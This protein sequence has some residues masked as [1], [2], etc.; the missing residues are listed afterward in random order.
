MS[1]REK[2]RTVFALAVL[3][4]LLSAMAAFITAARLRSAQGW[5]THTHLVEAAL[6][7]FNASVATTGRL[8]VQYLDTGN[9]QFLRQEEIAFTDVQKKL[10]RVRDLTADNP[11]ERVNCE[12]LQNLADTRIGLVRQ[13][14]LMKQG[15]QSTLQK[16]SEMTQ[17]IVTVATQTDALTQ[18]MHMQERLLLEERTGTAERLFGWMVF[19]VMTALAAALVLFLIYYRLLNAELKER[20]RAQASL[21]NLS[22]RLMNLQDEER[23]KFSRELHDSLGQNL[24]ALKMLLP[25]G[26]GNQP[27]NRNLAECMDIVDK[28]ISEIRTISHLLHPPLLDEAGLAVA[29]KWYV[30]GFA[31][32]SKIHVETDIPDDLGRLPS[33]VELTLFRILQEGLTNIHR[34]SGAS[35]AEVTLARSPGGLVLRIRDHGVGIEED[36]LSRFYS[37]NSGTGVGLAG[38]RERIR[39][40]GG[41]LEI[42]SDHGTAV[43]ATVPAREE[44]NLGNPGAVAGL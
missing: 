33:A 5:V 31:Q 7:D 38:M 44:A 39:E 17:Q 41:R 42:H 14:L 25:S 15:G 43:E 34:H 10:A 26:D 13:A 1:P 29:I 2:A 40:L 19:I 21:R 4:V 18:K 6:E 37:E 20:E 30:D 36:V 8:R 32:R 24:A 3:L 27:G 16:Q 28:S 23:R 22:V 9:E 12:N 35:K 11:L